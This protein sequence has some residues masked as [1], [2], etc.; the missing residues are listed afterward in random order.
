MSHSLF[1]RWIPGLMI[2]LTTVWMVPDA[3]A[4]RG[5]GG[6]G[7]GGRGGGSG[8]QVGSGGGQS[9]GNAGQNR[10][11]P[12]S[13]V[14]S[15]GGSSRNVIT[16]QPAGPSRNNYRINRG[17][18]NLRAPSNVARNYPGRYPA[19]R[20]FGR[21]GFYGRY[22]VGF[23]PWR[24][25]VF[26]APGYW[27]GG[28]IA[29]AYSAPYYA[30]YPYDASVAATDEQDQYVET[31]TATSQ[32]NDFLRDA[33]AA[34]H[35]GDY[36]EAIRLANHALVDSPQDG[37]VHLFTAQTLFALGDYE[38]AAAAIHQGAS[39]LPEG[40]WGS[41]V[42][43]YQRYYHG[44]DF[45]HQMDELN[46]FIGENSDAAYAYFVRGYE[47]GFLGHHEMAIK[48]LTKAVELESRDELAV[49]LIERFGGVPPTSSSQGEE[50]ARAPAPSVN[51]AE[52]APPPL[53]EPPQ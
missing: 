10:S 23:Y 2:L 49:R 29:G 5:G 36:E 32:T 38:G 31:S 24:F 21:Y 52:A 15:S 53:P 13:Q 25:G 16:A 17:T 45:V 46:R 20:Y 14:R 3:V 41:I 34:F 1:M 12:S 43:N 8:N 50:A 4:Q 48:D 26:G 40:D 33:E 47:H 39:L 35:A 18:T 11:R 9:R 30:Y 6:K 44:R 19:G 37:R 51:H 22:G 42:E 27:G 7:S 28:G